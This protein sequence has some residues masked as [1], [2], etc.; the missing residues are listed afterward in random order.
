[1]TVCDCYSNK[2]ELVPFQL[3]NDLVDFNKRQHKHTVLNHC[4]SPSHK[5]HT[6]IISLTQEYNLK[7]TASHTRMRTRQG[8]VE[9]RVR[10]SPCAAE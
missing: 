4:I 3:I 9:K 8:D 2:K 6:H 10:H 5:T 7:G 1:M